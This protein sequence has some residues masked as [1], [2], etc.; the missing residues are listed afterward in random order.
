MDSR[1]G[2]LI[3]KTT[4][5]GLVIYH[6]WELTSEERVPKT[7]TIKASEQTA[8][9]QGAAIF[10]LSLID[11]DQKYNLFIAFHKSPNSNTDFVSQTDKCFGK[12]QDISRN[13]LAFCLLPAFPPLH[14]II[15]NNSPP[16]FGYL[17]RPAKVSILLQQGVRFFFLSFSLSPTSMT[18]ATISG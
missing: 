5:S 1:L 14:N 6:L 2:G 9:Q 15:K 12:L 4:L 18:N 7:P 16:A 8:K 13:S 11:P 10:P 3:L 17:V